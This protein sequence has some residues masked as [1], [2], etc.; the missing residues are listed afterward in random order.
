L[1]PGDLVE[2]T[3]VVHGHDEAPVVPALRVVGHVDEGVVAEHLHGAVAH[4][5]DPGRSG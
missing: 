5:G 4:R 2:V 3:V 1:L